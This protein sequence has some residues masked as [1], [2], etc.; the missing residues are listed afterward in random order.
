MIRKFS[1]FLIF[2]HSFVDVDLKN[3]YFVLQILIKKT[4]VAM[5]MTMNPSAVTKLELP[6]D[7]RA[8]FR[9]VTLITPDYS[10]LLR[11]KCAASGLKAPAILGTRLKMVRDLANDLL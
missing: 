9:T 4:S 6:N 8:L 3:C 11:A 7:V 10:M 5:F 2:S 1:H